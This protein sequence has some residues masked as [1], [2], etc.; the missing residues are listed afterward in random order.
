MHLCIM[1]ARERDRKTQRAW[2]IAKVPSFPVFIFSLSHLTH[3][4]A[5]F[6]PEPGQ[7]IHLPLSKKKLRRASKWLDFLV[8]VWFWSALDL[9]LNQRVR[10]WSL[11]RLTKTYLMARLRG[12]WAERIRLLCHNFARTICHYVFESV[13][14]TGKDRR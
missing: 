6:V 13:T 14:S 12:L 4:C 1:T 8:N 10:S 7:N 9:T 2:R 5:C 11:R 3:D